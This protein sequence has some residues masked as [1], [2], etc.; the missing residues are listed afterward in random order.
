[1]CAKCETMD[2][3]YPRKMLQTEVL[4]VA[5]GKNVTGM[6]QSLAVPMHRSFKSEF[7]HWYYEHVQTSVRQDILAD[8]TAEKSAPC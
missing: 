5:Y 2:K 7:W 3:Q 8:G 6:I 1:M 4:A